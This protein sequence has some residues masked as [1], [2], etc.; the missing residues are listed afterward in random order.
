MVL[1][2]DFTAE[3]A[4]ELSVKKGDVVAIISRVSPESVFA[5]DPVSRKGGIVPINFLE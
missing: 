2:E 5:Y 1:I 3:F 4:E